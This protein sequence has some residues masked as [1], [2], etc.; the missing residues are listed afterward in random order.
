MSPA[1]DTPDAAPASRETFLASLDRADALVQA[2]PEGGWA[3]TTPCDGWCV[4]DVVAHITGTLGKVG[5]T[6]GGGTYAGEPAMPSR[7]A[8]HTVD[9]TR[10]AWALARDEVR[11]ALGG[12]DLDAV[13]SG[14]RG[15]VPV[16]ELLRL[17]AADLCVHGWDIA[18]S[19]GQD[20]ELPGDL[21]AHV[22]SVVDPLPEP[23]LRSPGLFGA[24]VAAPDDASETDRLMAW[25]GRARPTDA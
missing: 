9:D 1:A 24:E 4:E 3:A 6:L 22:R 15:E 10:A 11:D 7:S 14:P 16:H 17:P 13:V 23:V 18:V 20:A 21:V 8:D 5:E 2:V 12:A 25:L 19:T